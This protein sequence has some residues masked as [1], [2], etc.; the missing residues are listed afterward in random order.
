MGPASGREIAQARDAD[1]DLAVS[2]DAIPEGVRVHLKLETGMGRWGLSSC[3][4]RQ[5]RLSV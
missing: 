2:D 3:R 5:S 4:N 1:L